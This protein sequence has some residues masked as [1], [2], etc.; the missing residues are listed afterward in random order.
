MDDLGGGLVGMKHS[1]L[2]NFVGNNADDAVEEFSKLA[3]TQEGTGL[4][5]LA[6][7]VS[8][9]CKQAILSGGSCAIPQVVI[10][11]TQGLNNLA[12]E[13][14]RFAG[15]TLSLVDNSPSRNAFE[16]KVPAN[17]ESVVLQADN[18]KGMKWVENGIE[19]RVSNPRISSNGFDYPD[20]YVRIGKKVGVDQNGKD[21]FEYMDKLGN[22]LS[23][24]AQYNA[25]TH[26]H[27]KG[28]K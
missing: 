21:I 9:T 20:W 7:S 16:L 27:I 2:M 6:K 13:A 11:T 18:R 25:T 10:D 23:D 22:W 3:K 8:N 24:T 19:Y 4:V 12:S 15:K 17:L 1:S 5:K 26:F 28:F 14:R